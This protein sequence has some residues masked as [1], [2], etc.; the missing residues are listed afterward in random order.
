MGLKF[1]CHLCEHPMHV[2]DFLAGKRGKCPQC[3]GS[4]RIPANGEEYSLPILADLKGTE[5]ANELA[6][7]VA[8]VTTTNDHRTHVASVVTSKAT[9]TPNETRTPSD[10][11]TSTT[12]PAKSSGSASS[13]APAKPTSVIPEVI[14][15]APNAAWYVRPPSGGQY[16]P[17]IGSVFWDWLNE[18]RVGESS[19]V[20]R[21]GWGTWQTAKEVFPDFFRPSPITA[22]A[23]P[24]H[25]TFA[26]EPVTP[27][28]A[29]V[30]PPASVPKAPTSQ[31]AS[32]QAAFP[33]SVP[34]AQPQ[35]MGID[36]TV[37]SRRS[38]Q[39]RR[40]KSHS[41]NLVLLVG[42]SLVALILVVVLVVVLV[43]Q[44]GS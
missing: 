33:Q 42:L 26:P 5:S 30:S 13:S 19:L 43:M 22:P 9:S 35:P 7:E 38:V 8:A 29:A 3:G 14:S 28:L 40:K 17:A 21:E 24:P 23:K 41:Q 15:E 18:K 25:A 1:L 11:A 44:S 39:I 31:A 36:S 4:I 32:P 20:W 16:G 12:E 27:P 2:K 10:R 6:N 34:T 37:E